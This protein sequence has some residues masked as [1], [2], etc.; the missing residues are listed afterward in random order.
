VK[1]IH[2]LIVGSAAWQSA[3]L[4][5]R[6]LE[7]EQLRDSL[8]TASGELDLTAGG[9]PQDAM[10]EGSRRRTIYG[11]VDRQYVP[12]TFTMFDFPHPDVHS[13]Q[14]N[15]T[16]VPQQALFFLNSPFVANRARALVK[17]AGDAASADRVQL[18]HRWLYQRDARPQEVERALQ[19]IEAVGTGPPGDGMLN[20]WE[21]YAQVL[22]LANEFSFYE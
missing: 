20:P 14:R 16:L 12:P 3:A 7:F 15:E 19:F 11:L 18:F 4:P 9:R 17:R 13:S 5:R 2:R 22:I 21:Q 1:A 10:A 6:R 8:L